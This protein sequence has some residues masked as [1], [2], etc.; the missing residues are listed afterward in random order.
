MAKTKREPLICFSTR[1]SIT[2]ATI[3]WG[4]WLDSFCSFSPNYTNHR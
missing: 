1:E 2:T 4:W 3:S